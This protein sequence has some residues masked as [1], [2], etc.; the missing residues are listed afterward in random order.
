MDRSMTTTIERLPFTASGGHSAEL[1]KLKRFDQI[2]SPGSLLL[3]DPTHPVS[4]WGSGVPADNAILPN[5]V[6]PIALAVMGS[7]TPAD[8]RPLFRKASA[9][10]GSAGLIERTGKGG[11][12]A[13]SPQSG[14]AVAGSGP[15]VQFPT[16]LVKYWLDNPSHALY[17]SIW[18]RLTRAAAT[19]F[20]SAGVAGFSPNSQQTNG[21]L[22]VIAPAA[23]GNI[24]T[25]PSAGMPHLAGVRA[26]PTENPGAAGPKLTIAAQ[27]GFGIFDNG[28][29]NAWKMYPD[30]VPPVSPGYNAAVGSK[31]G[32]GVF[33]GPTMGLAT[34]DN[35]GAIGSQAIAAQGASAN[36]DKA[37]S[38]AFYRCYVEDL[39][40]SGRTFAEVAD[41]DQQ[42]YTKEV[43]TAGGRYHN[44]SFTAV[45]A[46][47]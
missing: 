18:W 26:L 24:G 33:F 5:L 23:G 41:L 45:S 40:V 21:G 6:E 37:P 14:A 39:T 36:K 11:V 38:F 34:V 13:I 28:G 7:S 17:F 19:G 31:Y 29:A 47:P 22:Q 20:G 44:D 4:A 9:F 35:S 15:A 8:A 42:L 46:L 30:V 10:T 12:H 32:G 16:R 1:P 43:L 3:I 25:R 2:E 27:L